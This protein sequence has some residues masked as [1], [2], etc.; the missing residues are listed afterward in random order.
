MTIGS[1]E[2]ERI[3]RSRGMRVTSQRHHIFEAVNRL[4]HATPE[5]ILDEVAAQLPGMTLSTVYRALEALEEVDL[6]THTHLGHSPLTYHAVDDHQHIHLVCE[7]CQQVISADSSLA[8]ALRH[9]IAQAYEFDVDPTHMAI[10][11]RC[12]NCRVVAP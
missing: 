2:F 3:L 4:K 11:G 7:T 1:E 10:A 9:Q 12:K 8:D 5:A 6:V